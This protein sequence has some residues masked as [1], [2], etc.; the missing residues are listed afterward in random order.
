MGG[1]ERG[2]QGATGE[3]DAARGARTGRASVVAVVVIV[4][5]VVALVVGWRVWSAGQTDGGTAGVARVTDGDGQVLELPLDEDAERVVTTSLGTNVVEVR[6]G[7]VR[8]READCPNQDCVNQGWIDAAGEQI[9]CLPHHLVVQ[10]VGG[11]S[12]SVDVW[13]R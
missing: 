2:R 1:R 10:V 7:R 6:D 13:G 11:A 8:V 4:A 12:S 5:A 3:R 9:V